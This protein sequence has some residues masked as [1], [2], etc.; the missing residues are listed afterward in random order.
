MMVLLKNIPIGTNHNEIKSFIQ[1]AMNG[2]LLKAK[3]N[4][5]KLEILALNDKNTKQVEYH[6]VAQIEP[7]KAALRA[8][9][10]LNGLTLRGKPITVRQFHVRDPK[11]DRRR[12]SHGESSIHKEKR[13]NPDRRRNLDMYNVAKPH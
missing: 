7:E 5:S 12:E 1:P 13:V 10:T 2:G 3:G 11:N 4:L 8:I 6:A 9:Q